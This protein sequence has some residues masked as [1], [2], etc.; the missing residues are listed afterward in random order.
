M[1]TPS[2]TE[3]KDAILK[4]LVPSITSMV[5]NKSPSSAD[6]IN[7]LTSV[8]QMVETYPSLKGSEKK[9]L[10]I[11]IINEILDTHIKDETLRASLKLVVT[12]T[13]PTVVDV[14]IKASKGLLELNKKCCPNCCCVVM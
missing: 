1:T 4:K 9:Q 8:M 5:E 6:I 14:I 11:D 12:S 13:V 7:L 3:I 2:E 10:A